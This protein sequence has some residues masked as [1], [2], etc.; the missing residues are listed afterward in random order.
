MLVVRTLALELHSLRCSL[1]SVTPSCVTL[2]N[3]LHLSKS[4]CSPTVKCAHFTEPHGTGVR[5]DEDNDCVELHL[6]GAQVNGRVYFQRIRRVG[7]ETSHRLEA[8]RF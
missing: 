5:I 8:R 3:S 2:N 4:Q 7:L 1:I 6:V